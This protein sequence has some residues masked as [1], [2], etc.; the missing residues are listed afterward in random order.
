MSYPWYYAGLHAGKNLTFARLAVK[1]AL[2]L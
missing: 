1:H 2:G